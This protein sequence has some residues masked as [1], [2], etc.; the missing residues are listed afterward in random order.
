MY[1]LLLELLVT[2]KYTYTY[3]YVVITQYT[4]ADT[5]TDTETHNA[6]TRAHTRAHTHTRLHTKMKI[7][8]HRN[9][10]IIMT[11]ILVITN[12]IRQFSLR[13]CSKYLDIIQP[14]Y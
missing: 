11:S 10:L 13:I 12:D 1:Y 9:T 8:F 7:T 4:H 14:T 3:I 2:P 6:H 5:D